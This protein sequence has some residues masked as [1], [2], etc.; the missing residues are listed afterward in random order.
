MSGTGQGIDGE[1]LPHVFERFWRER[2]KPNCDEKASASR[3]LMV[4]FEHTRD[5]ERYPLA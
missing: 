1:A 5:L 2:A 3:P 4:T